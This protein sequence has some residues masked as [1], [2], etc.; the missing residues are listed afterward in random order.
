[1]LRISVAGLEAC[2]KELIADGNNPRFGNMIAGSHTV[3]TQAFQ[4]WM[5]KPARELGWPFRQDSI[6]TAYVEPLD[7]YADMG[8]LL[9][10]ECWKPDDEVESVAYFC[11][12]VEDGRGTP[13]TAST[14]V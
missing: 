5:R 4:L 9:P 13:S 2:C 12:V 14:T 6:M 1:M 8:Q 10:R 11:G 3:M 7:T